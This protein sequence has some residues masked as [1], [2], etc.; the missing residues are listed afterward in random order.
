MADKV[1]LYDS[2]ALVL[3]GGIEMDK[4]ETSRA[5]KP[6]ALL[7]WEWGEGLGH[8]NNLNFV[9][10]TLLE[11]GFEIAIAVRNKKAAWTVINNPLIK[12]IQ[13][14]PWSRRER[15]KF[16]QPHDIAGILYN[17]GFTDLNCLQRCISGWKAII[18][19]HNPSLIVSE[20]APGL[21]AASVGSSI[22]RVSIGSSFAEPDPNKTLMEFR[23][24]YPDP[25]P[26]DYQ[27]SV[28]D[29][30]NRALARLG[31]PTLETLNEL[32]LTDQTIITSIPELDAYGY[33]LNAHYLGPIN[34]IQSCRGIEKTDRNS[35]PRIFVYLKTESVFFDTAMDALSSLDIEVIA[36]VPGV[37][38]HQV[39]NYLRPGFTVSDSPFVIEEALAWCDL[40]VHH[41]GNS[42]TGQSVLAGRA[43]LLFPNHHEQQVT[44]DRAEASGMAVHLNSQDV[45]RVKSVL[46]NLL[47]AI[48]QF[49]S[50][51]QNNINYM[52]MTSE[53]QRN[54]VKNLLIDSGYYY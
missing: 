53:W 19:S 33:R 36:F 45:D 40:V 4:S 23:E 14:P 48:G 25:I 37:K 7:G 18:D 10:E 17:I 20:F 52:H 32:F 3:S 2:S 8:L 39:Q 13:A 15:A 31:S 27:L 5:Q 9:A 6:T 34:G 24:R 12:I 1:D 50:N 35:A 11:E 42:L 26:K 22:K 47:N 16:L 51:T 38:H 29:N 44:A 21:L 43:Q 49:Q 30:L 28:L 54:T 46:R 41:G